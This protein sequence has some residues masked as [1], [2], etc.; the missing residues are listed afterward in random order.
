MRKKELL[1]EIKKIKKKNELLYESKENLWK[2]LLEAKKN[3]RESILKDYDIAILIKDCRTYL[4]Q[5]GVEEKNIRNFTLSQN[6]GS[7]PVIEIEKALYGGK[8]NE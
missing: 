7:V 3:N 6:E 4:L 1:D 2:Q 8:D 5:K